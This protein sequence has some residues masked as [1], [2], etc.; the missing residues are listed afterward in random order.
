M[1][2]NY[3]GF[4]SD[5]GNF[6]PPDDV[7]A[8]DGGDLGAGGIR[9]GLYLPDEPVQA[10]L[11]FHH[12]GG[13]SRQGYGGL[14]DAVRRRAPVAVLVPDL[15]GHGDSAGDR[16]FAATPEAVWADVDRLVD[17]VRARWPA[18]LIAASTWQQKN[19]KSILT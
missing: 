6:T 14:A 16:G 4:L 17:T 2:L 5:P 1:S 9:A 18:A 7:L 10:V 12:G 15:R 3:D 13:A 8:L 19:R 11:I